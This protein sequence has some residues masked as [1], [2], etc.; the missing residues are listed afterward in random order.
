MDAAEC[1]SCTVYQS[2]SIEQRS[3][4]TGGA[5]YKKQFL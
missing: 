4:E 3:V 1:V 2:R 5:T